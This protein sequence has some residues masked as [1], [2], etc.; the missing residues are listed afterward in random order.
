MS[1]RISTPPEEAVEALRAVKAELSERKHSTAELAKQLGITRQAVY[2]WH[3]IPAEWVKR[4]AE[5]TGI[6]PYR[7]RP[8]LYD[9]P[10]PPRRRRVAVG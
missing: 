2:G 6:P 3:A 9:E 10:P 8:D 5:L 7:L 1:R 4:I